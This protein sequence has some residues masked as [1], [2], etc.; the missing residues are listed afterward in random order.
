MCSAKN[1]GPH[2][3]LVI[4]HV[5]AFAASSQNSKGWGFAGFAQEQLT[6]AKPFGLFC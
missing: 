5:V 4:S 3:R 6:Q 2:R 1:S